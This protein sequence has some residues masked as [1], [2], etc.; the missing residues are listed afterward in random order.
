[1]DAIEAAGFDE[2]STTPLLKAEGAL[3]RANAH[4]RLR[5][6]E[7][8]H[9]ELSIARAYGFASPFRSLERD[10]N[11]TEA[12]VAFMEGSFKEAS[13][14]LALPLPFESD[15]PL[16]FRETAPLWDEH[17]V[18]ARAYELEGHLAGVRGDAAAQSVAFRQALR[19]LAESSTADAWLAANI[20]STLSMNLRDWPDPAATEE[21]RGIVAD[22]AW[23]SDMATQRFQLSRSFGLSAALAGNHMEAFRYY[24]QANKEAPKAIFRIVAMIDRV[25]LSRELGFSSGAF[26]ADEMQ[27]IADLAGDVNWSVC[28]GEEHVTLLLLAQC[29]AS[30]DVSQAARFYDRYVGLHAK[31]GALS[32]FGTFDGWS[33][34]EG[35]WRRRS[36]VA[37]GA[38]VPRLRRSWVQLARGS[39]G[40][41]TPRDRSD[42]GSCADRCGSCHREQSDVMDRA[43]YRVAARS[44]GSLTL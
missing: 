36:S 28:V 24:R 19:T 15:R 4:A 39:R 17:H 6:F 10:L 43:A 23:T 1:M 12:G 40:S 25:I 7:A 44:G 13:R 31:T 33:D 30:Y 21:L 32:G 5:N 22:F 27:E 9:Y 42:E 29:F 14:L 3:L 11:V 38:C 16:F 26:L 35:S 8:A 20:A 34:R 37:L 18:Q 41:R 2:S